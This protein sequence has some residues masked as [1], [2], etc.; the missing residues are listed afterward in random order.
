M[1]GGIASN[2]I[3]Y[4]GGERCGDLPIDLISIGAL[5]GVVVGLVV[6]AVRREQDDRFMRYGVP[7]GIFF[8]VLLA[9]FGAGL[10]V[11]ERLD[12]S[13][14]VKY[15]GLEVASRLERNVSE[16][17]SY[18]LTI[19]APEGDSCGQGW[20]VSASSEEQFRQAVPG[21]RTVNMVVGRGFLGY[22]WC[23]SLTVR[24]A[25]KRTGGRR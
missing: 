1:V 20:I 23:R 4:E 11:N 6:F 9:V 24:T 13:M 19:V 10:L 2:P 18:S 15:V 8:G 21:E 14:P 3:I 12:A 7:I 5:S 17:T 22:R 25:P 16:N